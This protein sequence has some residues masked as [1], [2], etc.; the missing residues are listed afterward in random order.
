M[1]TRHT[2]KPPSFQLELMRHDPVMRE[3]FQK[4]AQWLCEN[5][6]DELDALREV[7]A[8]EDTP[9]TVVANDLLCDAT[10]YVGA[11][12]RII[13]GVI[14]NA[15]AN[16]VANSRVLGFC[17]S[18]STPTLCDV[19]LAGQ[20]G[21]VL[22]GLNIAQDYFLSSTV[23]GGLQTSPPGAS[24]HVVAL[25]GRPLSA[26]NMIINIALRMQRS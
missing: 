20:T 18:K 11:A 16:S 25:L 19:A 26:T 15:Q 5:L 4:L 22:V 8:T 6:P 2:C 1:A 12:V 23:A 24:G 10:V 9:T 17:I 14:H 3:S 7:I 21:D 13:G